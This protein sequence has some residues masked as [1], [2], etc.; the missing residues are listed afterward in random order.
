MTNLDQHPAHPMVAHLVTP[1]HGQ[2]GLAAA[3]QGF[4]IV[5]IEIEERVA[6]GQGLATGEVVTCIGA[7][8]YRQSSF[9]V[10]FVAIIRSMP[11]RSFRDLRWRPSPISC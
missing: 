5:R 9:G 6:V 3:E 1:A 7:V 8:G 2:Q 11:T 4:G 10:K